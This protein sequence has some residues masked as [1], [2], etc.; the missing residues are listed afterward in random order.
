M[1]VLATDKNA[2]S[3]LVGKTVTGYESVGWDGEKG[4]DEPY[5]FELHF[6]SGNR[7]CVRPIYD[8]DG[9]YLIVELDSGERI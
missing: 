8:I 1:V 2:L 4:I 9:S 7:L 3:F 5:C 6:S